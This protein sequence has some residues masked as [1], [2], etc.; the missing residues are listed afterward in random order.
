[1]FNRLMPKEED[2]YGLLEEVANFVIQ[3]AEHLKQLLGDYTDVDQKLLGL[4]NLEHA[5][6]R[7]THSTVNRLNE[8]FIT[9]FDREDIHQLVITVDDVLDTTEAAAQ[10]MQMCRI[11]KPTEDIRK[12]GSI[13]LEQTR[14]IHRAINA[15]RDMR[16]YKE[17][18]D[19]CIE[20]HRLEK[21]ADDIMKRAIERL[22][23]EEKDAI[24]ILKMKEV[25]ENLEVVSDRCESVANLI[26]GIAVKMS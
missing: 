14:C 6:D 7:V 3:G 22:F 24:E 1:M 13:I 16:N 5:C 25:Y 20:I 11:K 18:M 4:E 21:A 17:I 2:F 12:M 19:Q 9:P 10:R 26:Q 23:D 8:T 15:L